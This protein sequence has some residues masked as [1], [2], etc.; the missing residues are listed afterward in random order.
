MREVHV[1]Q[2]QAPVRLHR[3]VDD[4]VADDLVGA[5]IGRVA[6]DADR[7]VRAVSFERT[8]R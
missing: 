3:A 7:Q 5:R 8:R 4:D 1:D 2:V 6:V